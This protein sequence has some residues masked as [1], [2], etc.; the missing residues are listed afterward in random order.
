ML[1]RFE[2][3]SQLT[4]CYLLRFVFQG[5][6]Q[7][8]HIPFNQKRTSHHPHDF[9]NVPFNVQ[10]MFDNGNQTIRTD[11]RINLYSYS[12]FGLSPKS[13]YSK[14]L[15]YPLKKQFHLPSVFVEKHYLFRG[16]DEII[17]VECEC[18]MQIRYVS[19]N[20]SDFPGVVLYVA[21]SRKPDCFVPENIA[22]VIEINT[23]FHYVSGVSFFSY[24]KE[25]VKLVYT[26]KTFQ[27]PIPTIK[28]VT[29]TWFIFNHIHSVD[30]VNF[31]FGDMNHS[32]NLCNDIKLCMNLY[33]CLCTSEICHLKTPM[34]RSIV[35]ESK[36]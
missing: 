20:S 24:G 1:I 33:T 5:E 9:I 16:K 28:Y 18:P 32:G 3:N 11:W 25:S 12:V 7:S 21:F 13:G 26:V 17:G 2:I 35:E 10:F 27:V 29:C 30:I 19:Y 36:A 14:V 6:E 34:Q 23:R 4:I 31:C 22:F 8:S 15:F